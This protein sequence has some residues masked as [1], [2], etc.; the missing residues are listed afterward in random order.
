[1]KLFLIIAATLA[2]LVFAQ[3]ALSHAMLERAN[4]R[5]GS[6]VQSAPAKVELWFSQELEPA[7]STLKVVDKAGRQVDMGDKTVDARERSRLVVSLPQLP[8][9][10]YRVVW[11]ALSVD[12]H[13]SEGDFT[14]VVA[15]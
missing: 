13:V 11:R 3:P 9:G 7:F 12:T 2:A 10:T 6:T 8:P 15:P 14:F 5:V 1:M 4:P